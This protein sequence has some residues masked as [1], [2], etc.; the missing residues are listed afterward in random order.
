MPG[1]AQDAVL[2]FE[3]VTVA[4]EDVVALADV[5]FSAFEGETRV[6]SGRRGPE[7]RCC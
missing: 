3:R 2:R 1:E 7:R 5:S 4:F 6:I